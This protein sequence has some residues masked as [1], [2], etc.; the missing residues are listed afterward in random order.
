MEKSRKRITLKF[1]A[2]KR[3]YLNLLS[4]IFVFSLFSCSKD[5]NNETATAN[6]IVLLYNNVKIID[7][8]SL[9][10]NM[11][12]TLL[13]QGKYEFSFIGNAPNISNGDIIIGA[14]GKGFI[15]MKLV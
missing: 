3:Q 13:N 6:D 5:D 4:I 7:S 9:P 1:N 2:M 11:D 10:L 14:Q 15:R 8:L 12:N